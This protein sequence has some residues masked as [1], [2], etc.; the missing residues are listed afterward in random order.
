MPGSSAT[1][2][3]TAITPEGIEA[4]LASGFP[5][6]RFSQS[7]EDHFETETSEERGR[8]NAVKLAVGLLFFD[9]FIITDF[10]I[11]PDIIQLAFLMRFAV[12]T[13]VMLAT[14]Y[15]ALRHPRPLT[16]ELLLVFNLWVLSSGV[17]VLIIFG[18]NPLK[19]VYLNSFVLIILFATMIVRI[20]FRSAVLGAVIFTV[21]YAIIIYYSSMADIPRVIAL[22]FLYIAGI[23]FTLFA[24][25]N[26]EREYR[27]NFLLARLQNM[28]NQELKSASVHDALT[29][30][31]NRRGLEED[32]LRLQRRVS[33]GMGKLYHLGVIILDIDHFKN[34]NDRSGHQAGD[35]CLRAVSRALTETLRSGTDRAYRYGG[36][37]F[38]ILMETSDDNQIMVAAERI[39][40]SVLN[41]TIAHPDSSVGPH[42][43]VSVGAAH[44]S[45][46]IVSAK[47]IIEAA[48]SAL[49][50][51]KA[52]GRNRSTLGTVTEDLVQQI[53]S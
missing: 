30:L 13:P 37:E 4:E 52:N 16:R 7:L 27:T 6:M 48:D 34:F 28:R 18:Q 36:E 14:I 47:T 32:L 51:S 49:Y 21:N 24:A 15:I 44:G 46:G 17:G 22:A 53:A 35:E 43:T 40:L 31:F 2:V 3:D 5:R 25:H 12:V 41:A 20:Q 9:L 50:I 45:I 8:S 42:V 11:F 38:M 26:L 23:I 19:D 39:R 33:A 29:D 1:S 10:L